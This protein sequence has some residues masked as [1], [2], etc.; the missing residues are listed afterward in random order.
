MN[1]LLDNMLAHADEG[2]VEGLMS[3]FKCKPG[4]YGEHDKF[5]GIKV[6]VTR[7]IVKECWRTTSF[8]QLEECLASEYHEVRLAGLLALVQ[9]FH[10]ARKDPEEQNRCVD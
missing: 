7:A 3:F 5:L 6:P 10:H 1:A 4:E 2:Q 9:R 8:G